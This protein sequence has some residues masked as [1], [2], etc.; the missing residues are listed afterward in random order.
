MAVLPDVISGVKTAKMHGREAAMRLVESGYAD[1]MA[2]IRFDRV[3][4]ST[5]DGAELLQRAG[6]RAGAFSRWT[7]AT[8]RTNRGCS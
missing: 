5:L 1:G 2:V 3:T 4:R 7:V 6:L 8:P